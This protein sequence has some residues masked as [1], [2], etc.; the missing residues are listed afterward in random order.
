M[1]KFWALGAEL[2]MAMCLLA[3]PD[4]LPHVDKMCQQHPRTRVVV[5]HFSRIGMKGPATEEQMT[6]L[7]RL[8]QHPQV[9]LKTSAFY[10]L[11]KKA[12]PYSDLAPMI[13]RLVKEFTARR[14]MWASD[15]PY[16][17]Q[18]PHDYASSLN[19]IRTGLDFLSEA[20]RTALLRS[21]AEEVFFRA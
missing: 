19:L 2:D 13:Q 5:D 14:L 7:C 3:D 21:T 4:A 1:Q 8:A 18:A 17:V 12:P 10:A 20:E 11:G 15:C 6:A 16:Q 9:Y